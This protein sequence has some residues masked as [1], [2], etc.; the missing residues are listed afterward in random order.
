M[1]VA[2]SP[3][4]LS[5]RAARVGRS[6]PP[7]VRSGKCPEGRL[8]ETLPSWLALDPRVHHHR[9]RQ[10]SSD[11]IQAALSTHAHHNMKGERASIKAMSTLV[12]WRYAG[13]HRNTVST[14]VL[15]KEQTT[16]RFS[17]GRDMKEGRS[18]GRAAPASCVGIVRM[19]SP[20]QRRASPS[21]T[22]SSAAPAGSGGSGA[23][24]PK[25]ARCRNHG[26]ISWL[27]GHKRQ[28]RFKE[29]AC[30]KCNLIAERQRIMAAQVALKRQQAAEDAIAMGLRA[31]ATG[32][33]LPFLPP[34][35]IFGLPLAA[36]AMAQAKGSGPRAK[37]AAARRAAKEAARTLHRQMRA[38]RDD[39]SGDDAA[40]LGERTPHDNSAEAP[41]TIKASRRISFHDDRAEHSTPRFA[42]PSPRP[43]ARRFNGRLGFA[44]PF[45]TVSPVPPRRDGNHIAVGSPLASPHERPPSQRDV[46]ADLPEPPPPSPDLSVSSSSPAGRSP[47]PAP[48]PSGRAASGSPLS[49]LT[50]V[51]PSH[52]PGFLQLVLRSCDG[53]L[54]RAI[55]QLAHA[56]PARSAFRALSPPMAHQGTFFRPAPGPF[57]R[58]QGA[59]FP[60]AFAAPAYPL[61]LPCP[62][63]CPQC[64]GTSSMLAG[65]APSPLR[66]GHVQQDAW[67]FLEDTGPDRLKDT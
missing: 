21:P 16:K 59:P 33:S 3:G 56:P 8:Q 55:E 4:E 47:P 41:N 52:R 31:V 48:S 34:G 38:G 35:P 12:P 1:S 7:G 10:E 45:A 36:K 66:A 22:G 42:F 65:L 62:P 61:L 49:T 46:A 9:S 2:P 13:T 40:E 60:L 50:R 63:G 24:R 26:M 32:T 23:R 51:F 64:T 19:S 11:G 37:E 54:I 20:S 17:K 43:C 18:C 25:C 30:A 67:S 5:K 44:S 29:C 39:G 27:K 6:A 15:V 14:Q 58:P 28:C 57:F 53:D